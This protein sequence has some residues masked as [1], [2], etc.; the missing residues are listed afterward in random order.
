MG[1]VSTDLGSSEPLRFGPSRISTMPIQ[2]NMK[3]MTDAMKI[4]M[5]ALITRSSGKLDVSTAHT[6]PE[7]GLFTECSGSM[8]SSITAKPGIESTIINKLNGLHDQGHLTQQIVRHILEETQQIKD[9]LILIQN[10]T[11]A[12]LTQ[13]LELV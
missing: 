13:Q 10:K 3:T 2:E 11:E 7:K 9:R 1:D 4:T 12:I 6:I 5:N 8:A